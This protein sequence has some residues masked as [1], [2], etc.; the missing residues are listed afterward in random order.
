VQ[1]ARAQQRCA[2][3]ISAG[4]SARVWNRLRQPRHVAAGRVE[5]PPL[6]GSHHSPFAIR[7]L[8]IHH[9]P[10]AIRRLFPFAIRYSL[11][12]S[13][14]RSPS[15]TIRH[16]PSLWRSRQGRSSAAAPLRF[17]PVTAPEFG[18]VSDSLAMSRQG[19]L[20]TR[21]YPDPTI[22]HSL[23]AIRRLSIHHSPFAIRRLFPFAIRYSLFAVSLRS[24]L[25]TTLAP[26]L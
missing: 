24:P 8:S 22:R 21:P 3:T 11:F 10:F 13:T 1:P 23:F 4:Y 6:P 12:L 19:G 7:R 18:I 15:F 25:A 5:N 2:P 20:R 16:W 14:R 9:S 17:Q 26:G